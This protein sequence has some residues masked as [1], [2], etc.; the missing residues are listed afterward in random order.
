MVATSAHHVVRVTVRVSVVA[1]HRDI[2]V[3]LPTSS[4]LAE[5]LPE[6]ARLVELPEVHRPWQA[7]TAGGAPLDMHMPLY[8]LKLHDGASVALHPE[9]PTPPPVVRDAADALAGAAGAARQVRGLD[10]AAT[11]AGLAAAVLVARAYLPWHAALGAAALLAL[12]VASA[13]RSRPA[14]AAV[15]VLASLCA[16]LWVAGAGQGTESAGLGALA[17]ALSA[18]VAVGVGA[19]LHLAGHALV[20]Y[21]VAT[22]A[23]VA[24]GALGVWL[25]GPLAPPALTLL[26]GVLAVMT[27]PG[28]ATRA[29][30]LTVPR[31]PTA[32]EEF[33]RSDAYQ[34]DV[35]ARSTTATAIASALSAAIATCCVPAVLWVGRAGGVW[36]CALCLGVA[37]ALVVYASRHHWAGPRL[38]LTAVALAAVVA[39]AEAAA[40]VGHPACIA[41]ACLAAL[42]ATTTVIWA[43]RVADL[44]P[45]TVVWFERAEIAATI[46]VIPLAVHLTGLFDMIRG[47]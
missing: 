30:G 24:V 44:E 25:P 36:A 18:V 46:A 42:T 15:P 10:A 41:L 35:D 4:T 23:L 29:A 20:A 5:V 39:A 8:A 17:A 3:T 11:F 2:D 7:T 22:C 26:A 27:T 33:D 32:G 13:G 28:V 14:F 34:D 45:T 12:V 40:Q 31:V 9:E 38:C 21:I 16:G 43:P 6:L 37:G 47:I 1:F 19:A